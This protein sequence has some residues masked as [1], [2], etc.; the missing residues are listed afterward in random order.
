MDDGTD[1]HR[2]RPP[3][4]LRPL[5]RGHSGR[6]AVACPCRH[7][8]DHPPRP[9]PPVL[10][11]QALPASPVPPLH[12][13]RPRCHLSDPHLHLL[14]A[15]QPLPPGAARQLLQHLRCR[16]LP[17]RLPQQ[18]HRPLEDGAGSWGQHIPRLRRT[19]PH[20]C[21]PRPP[22]PPVPP[23]VRLVPDAGGG[24]ACRIEVRPPAGG[25][26]DQRGEKE[27]GCRH[28]SRPGGAEE[29]PAEGAGA[30]L[31]DLDDYAGSRSGEH[32]V[33]HN[34]YGPVD[35]EVSC[36]KFHRDPAEGVI[37]RLY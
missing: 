9:L 10:H 29:E 24:G 11:P 36:R 4:L 33:E 20:R 1:P 19:L 16:R 26:V 21:L 2:H 23:P 6:A 12:P 30:S 7:R 31:P 18:R 17:R 25:R 15:E 35:D 32:V 13:P 28:R 14:R 8:L 3:R 34:T 27:A 37:L 22:A 5:L